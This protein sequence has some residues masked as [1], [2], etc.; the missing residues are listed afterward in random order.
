MVN[1][2]SGLREGHFDGADDPNGAVMELLRQL[3]LVDAGAEPAPPACLNGDPLPAGVTLFLTTACNLR[4]TY[5][6][7]SAGATA[8]VAMPLAVAR[9]GIDFVARNARRKGLR[10]FEVG[11]HGGGEP[12]A[13]WRTLTDSFAY[14]GER[15]RALGI[16]VRGALAT[17]GVLSD[18]R[19]DWITGHL[20]G[21]SVSF[22]GLPEIH[23]KHRIT[24]RG[25]GSSARVMHTLHRFEAARFPYGLRVTVTRDAIARLPDSIE[26]LCRHFSAGRIQIEPAYR[27]GR[28]EG[29][30]SAET[31]DFIA[32]FREAR[33]RAR[34]HGR[35]IFF[36]AVRLDTLT[37][38]FCAVSQDNF[39]LTTHGNVSACYEA[40]SE[41]SPWARVFFY[42]APDDDG[43]YRFDP[44]ALERLRRQAV[45]HRPYCRGCFAK[46]HCAGDCYYKA[47]AATGELEFAGSDRCHIIR[48]LSKDEILDRIAA[49][50]GLFW[51]APQQSFAGAP[52]MEKEIPL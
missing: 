21:A 30:P 20:H 15:A 26:F 9:R 51:H 46:W 49:S 17:N 45:Q 4:C 42:G 28:W 1:L 50:G 6:Y 5:C 48:E 25:G 36:S 40:F 34:R 39:C 22:D 3:E 37:N 12:T 38:H 23:D 14:A 31:A 35:E 10:S 2:L 19:I 8:G 44:A 27:L 47:L 32:A 43:G 41:S 7:A 13:N 11:Y 52:A 29:A 24:P 33:A 16:E 18:A